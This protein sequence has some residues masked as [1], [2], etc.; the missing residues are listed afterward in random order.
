[1]LQQPLE[2]VSYESILILATH[3][4]D[5]SWQSCVFPEIGCFQ[6]VSNSFSLTP[7]MWESQNKWKLL[8][9]ENSQ[10]CSRLSWKES[11]NITFCIS[12]F[13]P[14]VTC[15]PSNTHTHT[16]CAWAKYNKGRKRK[17]S[18]RKKKG[19]KKTEKVWRLHINPMKVLALII[20]PFFTKSFALII[21]IIF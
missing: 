10:L 2:N 4:Y 18:E 3:F 6:S 9:L 5:F 16:L 20:V 15:H 14:L 11:T 17:R 8:K 7:D 13:C 19:E 21:I 1:M 12:R